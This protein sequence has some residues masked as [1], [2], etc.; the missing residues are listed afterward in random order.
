VQ[1]YF[2]TISTA[3]P[4]IRTGKLH[5]LAVTSAKRSSVAPELPTVAEAGVTG[6]E[7]SSW[8]GILA[9]ART[10]R[11]VIEKLHS[12]IVKI[13]QT[14]EVKASFL[15]DGLETVG[16]SPGEFEAIIKA[17]IAKWRKL[18]KA[19]GIPAE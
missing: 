15:R 19:A 11:P 17:E 4:H 12:E 1:V 14:P 18:V 5:A 6:Y 7:H 8:V 9:P 10:P 16:N 13:V 2:A 3:L